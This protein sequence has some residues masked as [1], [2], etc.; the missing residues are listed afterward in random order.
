TWRWHV[1]RETFWP[2]KSLV[3]E[4]VRQ[5]SLD[6]LTQ[7]ASRK[8]MAWLPDSI[9]RKHEGAQEKM[10][11]INH[12]SLRY[13]GPAGEQ[14]TIK[15]QAQ[16]TTHMV[17]YTLDGVTEKLADGDDINFTL[18]ERAGDESI[19]LQLVLD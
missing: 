15:V 9:G 18:V 5:R 1:R 17:E 14:V 8:S 2:S 12:D 11:E 3:T 13:S 19:N 6:D 10:K 4:R 7:K 16:G